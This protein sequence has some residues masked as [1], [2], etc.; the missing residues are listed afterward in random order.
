MTDLDLE[1]IKARAQAATPGP[2]RVGEDDAF[3]VSES[4]KDFRGRPEEVVWPD[5]QYA[6]TAHDGAHIAGMDPETTLALVDEVESLRERVLALLADLDY[7]EWRHSETLE[8]LVITPDMVE[9]AALAIAELD[10]W[11]TNEE[12]G[13]NLTGSRDDEFRDE[14]IEMARAALEAALGGY[15]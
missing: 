10:E 1:A 7:S 9:R 15:E 11:P 6:F 14:R 12:L 8:R 3:I 13:G 5:E 2:W 4:Q